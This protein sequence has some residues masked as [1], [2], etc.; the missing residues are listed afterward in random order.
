[1]T[2][3][4]WWKDAIVYCVDV[5]TFA[6]SNG[7]GWGDFDG[8][9]GRLGYLRDLG[10]DTLWL[11]PH[12]P[13]PMRDDGYDV[14]DYYSVDPRLGTIGDFLVMLRTAHRLGL[15]VVTEMVLN[16]SSDRHPWF[17]SARGR[18][19]SPYRDFYLWADEP[20]PDGRG[21]VFPGEQTETWTLDER[22]GQYYFHRYHDFEPDLAIGNPR[23]REQMR[24]IM[25]Y[26][27][28]LG[29]DGFRMD[30]LPFLV[31]KDG[32]PGA[33]RHGYLRRFREFVSGR[34]DDALLLGEANVDFEQQRAYFGD[35]RRPDEVSRAQMLFDFIL[36]AG[37]WLA[38][39]RGSAEPIERALR[40]RPSVPPAGQY[41]F[42][43][44]HHDELTLEKGV[45]PAEREEVF[46]A[47]APDPSARVYGRGI[48]RRLAPLL[49]GDPRRLRMALSLLM[50]LPG[51][52]V[53]LY[54]D[55][56]GVG[57][58]LELPGR[59]SVRVPM[60]WTADGGFSSAPRDRW[61]RPSLVEGQFG[62]RRVN[63][64]AQQGSADSLLRFTQQLISVRREC[65]EIG[66]EGGEIVDT[67]QSSALVLRYG[68]VITVHNL[69]DAP[70]EVRLG[71]VGRLTELCADQRHPPGSV[72]IGPYG[73]RWLTSA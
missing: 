62:S 25:G 39:A 40:G 21:V 69:S 17:M 31:D 73:F 27:L 35:P 33:D 1:M 68:R 6:D 18:R 38:L 65:P 13:S 7:D 26:W 16:H 57:D 61:V 24:R 59:W 53:L 28:E 42:F 52:P 60:Q 55:E 44:R 34:R 70:V 8:L 10:V 19:D 49:R 12:Y 46:K 50:A 15:R 41:A 5:K 30:S 64:A 11:L 66:R 29:V 67:G 54:G 23:V 3:G 45:S 4:W 58:N 71:D 72:G 14:A 22:T 2:S 56:I 9:T 48:R 20:K 37:V 51:T 32:E 36:Q 47:F 63:V 43:L